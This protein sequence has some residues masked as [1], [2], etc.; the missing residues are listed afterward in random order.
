MAV[1]TLYFKEHEGIGQSSMPWWSAFGSQSVNG[2]TFDLFKLS[3][4]EK[5][6]EEDQFSG[7]KQTRNNTEHD[8]NK[9]ISDTNTIQFTVFPGDCK[10]SSDGQKPPQTAEYHGHVDMGFRQPMIYAK[11]PHMDQ[12]YGL[13]SAYGSQI[14]GRM[15]LP[16]T[17]TTDEGPIFVNPKQYH[18]IIRRRKS[19]AKAELKNRLTRKTKP[20]MHLSRHLHAM[21]RPRGTGGRFL[22][23]GTGKGGTEA[24]KASHVTQISHPTASHSSEVFQSDSGTLNSPKEP[25]ISGSEVTSTYS[26]RH[27]DHHFSINY[28]SPPVHPF[29]MDSGQW[30]AAAADNCCNLKV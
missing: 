13:F 21:R 28:L 8:L 23:S 17:M 24:K 4:M 7:L 2:E 26:K 5:L 25:N 30:I 29:M 12:C 14:P 20:Y 6:T 1:K 18:G 3:S 11:Y 9:K 10:V 16:M 15:M 22:N 19:R 27:F